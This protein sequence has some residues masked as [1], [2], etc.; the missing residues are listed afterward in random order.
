MGALQ[1]TLPGLGGRVGVLAFGPAGVARPAGARARG[2]LAARRF[3]C[4]RGMPALA[5]SPRCSVRSS[6][7]AARRSP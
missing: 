3:A 7:R 6:A 5:R 2:A 4:R 1:C